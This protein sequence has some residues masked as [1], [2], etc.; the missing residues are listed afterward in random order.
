MTIVDVIGGPAVMAAAWLLA[1][2]KPT[3]GRPAPPP[4][5]PYRAGS[6]PGG[7]PGRELPPVE[8]AADMEITPEN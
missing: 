7:Y 4:P 8:R 2:R 5:P 1:A 6:F 3:P